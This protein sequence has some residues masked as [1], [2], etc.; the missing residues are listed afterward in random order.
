MLVSTVTSGSNTKE[1]TCLNQTVSGL[2]KSWLRRYGQDW[3]SSVYLIESNK[4]PLVVFSGEFPNWFGKGQSQLKDFRKCNNQQ[5]DYI[6]CCDYL[7]KRLGDFKKHLLTKKHD[8]NMMIKN[9]KHE[10]KKRNGATDTSAKNRLSSF[11]FQKTWKMFSDQ[12][13]CPVRRCMKSAFWM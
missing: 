5:Q 10:Q 12:F 9:D 1:K 11:A 8:D 2:L 4:Y 7:A 13:L 3:I 6:Q